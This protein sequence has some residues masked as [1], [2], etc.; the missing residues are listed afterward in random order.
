MQ[1]SETQTSRIQTKWD[2]NPPVTRAVRDNRCAKKGSDIN[3]LKNNK[4]LHEDS[5]R[6]LRGSKSAGLI[7]ETKRGEDIT[8]SSDPGYQT[9]KARKKHL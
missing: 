4:R 2:T 5:N 6:A 9:Q 1:V 3:D 7:M 8:N